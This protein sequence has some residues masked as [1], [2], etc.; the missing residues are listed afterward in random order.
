MSQ[1]IFWSIFHLFS[2]NNEILKTAQRLPLSYAL[3]FIFIS[4]IDFND[5]IFYFFGLQFSR[6][7]CWFEDWD[8]KSRAK[9]WLLHSWFM[10]LEL[11]WFVQTGDVWRKKN[12]FNVQN[13]MCI[14][15]TFQLTV[16]SVNPLTSCDKLML[17]MSVIWRSLLGLLPFIGQTKWINQ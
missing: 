1:Y 10:V 16:W 2:F 17:L 5:S 6:L 8:C 12:I 13:Y 11:K 7:S 3:N 4:C 15:E 9:A 14:T